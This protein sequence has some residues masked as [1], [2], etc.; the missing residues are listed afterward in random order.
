MTIFT[1]LLLFLVF[2]LVN[3]F[4]CPCNLGMVRLFCRHVSLFY[5]SLFLLLFIVPV[6][7]SFFPCSRYHYKEVICKGKN[8]E[9]CV[10]LTFDDGP[11]PQFTT[12]ILEVLAK[13]QVKATFFLIGKKIKNHEDLVCS[14][15]AEGHLLGNHSFNHG[16]FW[17][18][19][20]PVKMVKEILQTEIA[21]Q[22]ITHKKVRYFR[23]PYGVINPMVSSALKQINYKVIAWNRWSQD[24]IRNDPDKI[25]NSLLYKLRAGD[26]ILMHDTRQVTAEVLDKLIVSIYHLGFRIIPLDQLINIPAYE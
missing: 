3:F 2:N 7:F 13:H 5:I 21:I 20:P 14:I 9:N 26:I 11:D 16:N 12:R 15:F 25:L 19:L 22:Q 10:S 6:I 4:V 17:D 23:P 24:S 18:F 8:A 1:F